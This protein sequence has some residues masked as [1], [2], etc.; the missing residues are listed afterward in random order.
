MMIFA[1]HDMCRVCGGSGKDPPGQ[2]VYSGGY[3]GEPIR[4]AGW[5]WTANGTGQLGDCWECRGTGKATPV[6]R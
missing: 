6:G 1:K 3:F 2:P 4:F 5:Q